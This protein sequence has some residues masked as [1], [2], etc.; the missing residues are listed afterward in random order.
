MQQEILTLLTLAFSC[1]VV[2]EILRKSVDICKS[3]GEK[4]SGSFFIWT[5]CIVTLLVASDALRCKRSKSL[6]TTSQVLSRSSVLPHKPSILLSYSHPFWKLACTILTCFVVASSSRPNLSLSA[7]LGY[8]LI[9]LTPYPH[10][11]ET[12][13]VRFPFSQAV[14]CSCV[15]YNFLR[16]VYTFHAIQRDKENIGNVTVPLTSVT[17]TQTTRWLSRGWHKLVTKMQ[18]GKRF[19]YVYAVSWKKWLP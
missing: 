10:L 5:R 8:L 4:I 9:S 17:K 2:H 11:H 15:M 1:E 18:W 6:S 19:A 3:Y 14:F 7:T 16:N 13:L 12:K